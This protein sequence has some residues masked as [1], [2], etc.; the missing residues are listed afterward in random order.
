MLHPV[1]VIITLIAIGF[2]LLLTLL[3]LE[4][5]VAVMHHSSSQLVDAQ[6]LLRSKAQDYNCCLKCKWSKTIGMGNIF[7]SIQSI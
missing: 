3:L 7:Y 6:F 1:F 2:S 4:L 5:H